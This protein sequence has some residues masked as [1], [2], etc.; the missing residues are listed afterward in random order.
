MALTWG[1]W[2]L[3][4]LSHCWGSLSCRGRGPL[5]PLHGRN[6]SEDDCNS[7]VVVVILLW[8]CYLSCVHI[9][10]DILEKCGSD[11]L[12]LGSGDPANSPKTFSISKSSLLTV[13]WLLFFSKEQLALATIIQRK[14]ASHPLLQF[15]TPVDGHGVL[16]ACFSA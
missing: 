9:M 15:V 12:I 11:E 14:V 4:C 16:M 8:I 7:T 1:W 6:N 10:V 2:C 5:F 3:W 13:A